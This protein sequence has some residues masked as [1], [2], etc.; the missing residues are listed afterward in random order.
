M[1]Q[2]LDY[3]FSAERMASIIDT[4]LFDSVSN[5]KI[6]WM[7]ERRGMY[8]VKLGYRLVMSELLHTQRFC[9]EGERSKLQK[10]NVPHKVRNLLWRICQGYVSAHSKLQT[11]HV[12]C[13]LA[14]LWCGTN[15]ETDF[16]VFAQNSL[17]HKFYVIVACLW[18][19]FCNK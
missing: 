16:H 10:V 1:L 6:M 18:T 3:L 9:V 2:K 14:C 11:Q 8:T 7:Q 19:I 4:P 15:V 12:Q 5:D 17:M 13:D